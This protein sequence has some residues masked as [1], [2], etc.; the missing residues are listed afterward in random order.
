MKIFI[1]TTGEY[2]DYSIDSVFSSKELA[3]KYIEDNKDSL[4]NPM[5]E[6]YI[7]DSVVPQNGL[8]PFK[9]K[10]H[11]GGTSDVVIYKG[12]EQYKTNTNGLV[13]INIR[14]GINKYFL[15]AIIKARDKEHAAKI[16]NERRGQLIAENK[17]PEDPEWEVIN[18]NMED[19]EP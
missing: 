7:I 4:S 1:V 11:R 10:M 18:K 8:I 15:V 9:V 19:G 17:W 5:I 14:N 16:A 12:G 2:S 6:P 13:E 3:E